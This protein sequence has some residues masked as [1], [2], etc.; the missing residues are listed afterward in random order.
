MSQN[1]F[2]EIRRVNENGQEYWS[3]RDLYK[4]LDYVDYRNFQNLIEGRYPNMYI[5]S[6]IA[7]ATGQINSHIKNRRVQDTHY[8]QMI[9][10]RLQFG[11][12][13][14]VEINDL[15]LDNLPKVLD[16]SQKI[17]KVNNILY[18][19]SKKDKTIVNTG[20]SRYPKWS[21]V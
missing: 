1:I 5:S 6:Q 15:L 2:E 13:T 20:T 4:A 10:D 14:R 11:T 3:A 17:N 8:K 12:A 7:L 21:K 19:M 16:E 18:A 9:L